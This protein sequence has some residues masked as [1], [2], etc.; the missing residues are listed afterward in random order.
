V[1][2]HHNIETVVVLALVV[3]S[4]HAGPVDQTSIAD[5]NRVFHRLTFEGAVDPVFE[6]VSIGEDG[7][8]LISRFN[9]PGVQAP[10]S[11]NVG[12]IFPSS[13]N[14]D[15]NTVQQSI[16]EAFAVADPGD[17][18]YIHFIARGGLMPDA[19]ESGELNGSDEY[20]RLLSE[21]EPDALLTDDELAAM[22]SGLPAGVALLVVVDSCYGSGFAGGADDIVESDFVKV[23][24]TN[25]NCP[26]DPYVSLS[27]TFVSFTE[28]IVLRLIQG[29]VISGDDL[30]N[31][32]TGEGWDLDPP[33][34]STGDPQSGHSRYDGSQP[35]PTLTVD[36]ITG[37]VATLSG[38]NFTS[39]SSISVEVVTASTRVEVGTTMT[40][41]SGEFSSFVVDVNPPG[42]DLPEEYF[43][44]VAT[45]ASELYDW[46]L[47]RGESQI[48]Y[49]D[50]DA[51]G[52]NNGTSWADAYVFLYDALNGS[53]A[54]D[55]I[56]VADG[57]YV[58]TDKSCVDVNDC[59]GSPCMGNVCA[60][61]EPRLLY[62][63]VRNG[64]E[65]YGGFN[66]TEATLQDR[67]LS[68]GFETILSGDVEGDDVAESCSDH[69][70]CPT[71]G[72]ACLPPNFCV[73]DDS[74]PCATDMDCEVALVGGICRLQSSCERD[75]MHSCSTDDECFD[76]GERCIDATCII[77]RNVSD[78]SYFVMIDFSFD[79]FTT[80]DGFTIKG[81]NQT[82][83]PTDPALLIDAGAGI[84]AGAS[85]V[86][87][88]ALSTIR[89]CLITENSSKRG[90]G[91]FSSPAS[92]TSMVRIENV[93]FKRN[94]AY[95]FG[96][97]LFESGLGVISDCLFEKNVALG[98]E[99]VTPSGGAITWGGN[100]VIQ[101]CVFLENVAGSASAVL[102]SDAE[103][104][105]A[106]CC[107]GDN[108][109]FLGNT[110]GFAGIAEPTITD[111]LI[112]ESEEGTMA[113]L[114]PLPGGPAPGQAGSDFFA[115]VFVVGGSAQSIEV[116]DLLTIG[117][118]GSYEKDQSGPGVAGTISA[119]SILLTNSLAIA[120][121]HDVCTPEC[122]IPGD[123]DD[124]TC[125]R[126]PLISLEDNM[127]INCTG[128]FVIDGAEGGG[129]FG[130]IIPPPKLK[131]DGVSDLRVGG[132]LQ[133]IGS[134]A[135]VCRSSES[136]TVGGS[137]LN[138]ST[139]P[140]LIDC[141]MG[142]IVMEPGQLFGPGIRTFE[143]A[144]WNLGPT[145]SGLD[146]NF[147]L[148]TVEVGD[149]IV[150]QMVDE[151][152]N[153]TS[154]TGSCDEALYVD[155]LVVGSGATLETNG[156]AVYYENL[157][158]NGLIPGLGTDVQ[159]ITEPPIPACVVASECADAN[160][161][162]IRDDNCV[163]SDCQSEF[164]LCSFI[165]LTQFAD[166]GGAFGV[167][168]PDGFANIHDRNHSLSCFAG[169]NPC[170]PINVDAGSAF[171]ACPPDGFCNIHD[172]NHALAAFAGTNTCSCPA[173]PMPE[174]ESVIAGNAQIELA[175]DRN[176][177]QPGDKMEVH[178]F[179][180]SSDVHLR[181]YQLDLLVSGGQT[182]QLELVDIEIETRDDWV[183]DRSKG[184]F[185]AFNVTNGQML[186]GLNGQE[187]GTV[188]DS[189]YLATYTYNVSSDAAGSFV[190]DIASGREGQTY[191]VAVFDREILIEGTKPA[192]I[193]VSK[194][195]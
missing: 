145:E 32:L 62:F 133:L 9:H 88:F 194:R 193:S 25:A 190:L 118:N 43:L 50:T 183:F 30:E 142:S 22:V 122:V 177:V 52:A 92:E 123:P 45:D 137:F 130:T 113:E 163:W 96:G 71:L 125:C 60:W 8:Q 148:G 63:P 120:A 192:I 44:I 152:D 55:Q 159:E 12:F 168:P 82:V 115:R 36:S 132:N 85:G 67:D 151:F 140:E 111:V 89:N 150:V 156:C 116:T 54:G 48:I 1:N 146:D 75:P 58:P 20:L 108:F 86:N 170:D 166:M 83:G 134:A 99:S 109:A 80:I 56:W 110:I 14:E 61:S 126:Q 178:V 16:S 97:A 18:V 158:N 49:V 23:I 91:I 35:L 5:E 10:G 4:A 153:R 68:M 98:A 34:G 106:D 185:H 179:V 100:G 173:G 70:D 105:L 2:R 39:Q 42:P 15:K 38:A 139:A 155:T 81:G 31:Y 154:D 176:E 90:S 47:E 164:Q 127:D 119:G 77:N 66:G 128:D 84:L 187:G 162:N 59:F 72:A 157:V 131:T 53:Q 169:T 95:D 101:D 27:S 3:G 161:D 195:R 124:A 174:V 79:I 172:A 26:F 165:A 129:P 13:S 64:V 117:L 33:S 21:G 17:V 136:I 160:D 112:I 93:I 188:R 175:A 171:G 51:T 107:M 29:G 104:L 11:S 74:T 7:G 182:G 87:N 40:D 189:A 141:G 121:P 24:G 6:Q 76:L 143:V 41:M 102:A 144:G 149:G 135:M 65:L 167:C 19:G 78:N 138:H 57:T 180:S 69:A 184:A 37:S 181:S 186:A 103:G 147:S 114:C 28:D 191:L 94:H 73:N 46:H